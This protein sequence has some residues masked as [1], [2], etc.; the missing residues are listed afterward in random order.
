MKT[1]NLLKIIMIALLLRSCCTRDNG[2]LLDNTLNGKWHLVQVSGGFAGFNHLYEPGTISWEFNTAD[3]SLKVINTNTDKSLED[4]FETGNYS[5]DTTANRAT[6]ELCEK[7][8]LLNDIDYGCFEIENKRLIISQIETDG[9]YI[10][11]IRF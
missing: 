6:P 8:I 2:N 5:Y 7:V 11:L 1:V 3:N 10:K 4:L 9:Y